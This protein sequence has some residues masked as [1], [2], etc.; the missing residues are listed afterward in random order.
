LFGP[1]RRLYKRLAQ[2]SLFEGPAIYER[3]AR[4]P[5]P[6]LVRCAGEF[7]RLATEAIGEPVAAHEILFDAPPTHREVE[8]DVE[9][10]FLKEQRYRRLGGVSPVVRTL[11][12][13]QFDDY[14]KRV[15][16][17]GHPRIAQSLAKLDKFEKLLGEAIDHTEPRP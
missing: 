12:K 7:A 4:R 3:L 8:F 15:R 5:Y 1:T 9:V 13:E 16:V 10:Y 11:A 14:V 6:W 2:F 17:F